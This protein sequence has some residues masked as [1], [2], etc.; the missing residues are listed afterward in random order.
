MNQMFSRLATVGLLF[1]LSTA[2]AADN[3]FEALK[4]GKTDLYLRYRYEHVA[5][6][7]LQDAYAN[8]LRT[9]LGYK[10]GLFH[11]FGA[12][13]QLEDVRNLTDDGEYQI[14]G[15]RS[16]GHAV[17]ADPTGT[18]VQQA[19]IRYRGIPKSTLTAGRID[20]AHRDAPLHRFLGNVLW[21]QNWQ[22]YDAFRVE[23]SYLPATKID[24][25]YIW[26]VNRIFGEGS[27]LSD[28]NMN[29]HAL[30]I[31]YTG[32]KYGKIEP[33]MYLLD[34]DGLA[35]SSPT[36]PA[37]AV[38]PGRSAGYGSTATYGARLQG[39]YDVISKAAKVLYTFEYAHQ[40]DYAKNTRDISHNYYFIEGGVT[41]AFPGKLQ[42]VTLK[43]AIEMQEGDGLTAF[44]TPL[45]TNHAFQGWADK[46]L[47]TPRDGIR[48]IYGTL[49]VQ[50]YDANFLVM[51]HRLDSDNLDYQYGSEWN[52][53]VTRKF[54]KNYTALLKYAYYDGDNNATNI[55][56]NWRGANG[57]VAV[58]DR[59]RADADRSVFWAS[60]ETQF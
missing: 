50:A 56:R 14:P 46:F 19:N 41:K 15:Q 23:N 39:A 53:Q 5:D 34:F 10:T 57:L 47:L 32:F 9:A 44:T 36:A 49:A 35:G 59:N 24:Y 12:Y 3:L 51:Y 16:N 55:S 6:D 45:G 29:S 37:A 43:G 33:Y 58:P 31:D 26:N 17:I 28:Y 1:G 13:V 7:V 2:N 21:R 11:G 25:S 8:T 27:S 38:G 40:S 60:L 18:E 52:L 20:F 30:K 54:F 42:A 4:D 48:D 22:S